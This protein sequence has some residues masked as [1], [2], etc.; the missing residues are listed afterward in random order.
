MLDKIIDINYV[1][2]SDL[3]LERLLKWLHLI[4]ITT[5]IYIN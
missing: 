1:D 5:P 3:F 4:Q 2:I